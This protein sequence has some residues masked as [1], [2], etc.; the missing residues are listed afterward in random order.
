MFSV[1]EKITKIA[2]E[3]SAIV[4]HMYCCTDAAKVCGKIEQYNPGW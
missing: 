4:L 3:I 1:K 2:K